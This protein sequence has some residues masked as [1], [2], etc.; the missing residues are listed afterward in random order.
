MRF[1]L[2][3]KL[4]AIALLLLAIPFTGFRFS[5]LIQSELLESRKETLLFSAQAVASALGGRTGLFD[6]ELFHSLNPTRDL[7][8]FH[9]T[10]PIRL[11]G[12]T[13]DWEPQLNEA[14]EYGEDNL[15]RSKNPYNYSSFHFRHLTG[16]RMEY[17]YALF[18][19]TDDYLVYR[20]PNSLRVDQSDH[21]RIAMEDRSGTLHQYYVT[22]KQEGWVNGFLM[23]NDKQP[24]VPKQVE[25]AIQGM[26][27]KTTE[28]Y[29]IELRMPLTMIGQKL[30]FALADVDDPAQPDIECLVGTAQVDSGEN[31]GWLLSPS[32]T[33]SS[34]LA[35]L[36]RPQARILVVDSNR[37]VR[38]NSGSLEI[39]QYEK[40]AGQTGT[41]PSLLSRLLRPVS[42]FFTQ[43]FSS[44]KPEINNQPTTLDLS[45][46]TEAL[47]GTSSV[48][49]YTPEEPGVEIMAAITPLREGD[50]VVGAVVVEQTTNSILALQNKVI[51]ES[52]GLTILVS[53][54]GGLGLL[55]YATRLS[56]RIRQLGTQAAGAISENGQINTTI[57]ASSV[58]DELGDLSRILTSMLR[59]LELQI[60][61]RE[62]M[63]D[64]LEHEI[65][66]PLAGISASLKNLKNEL[67]HQSKDILDYLDWA[68][69]DVGRLE[70]LLTTIRD[71]TSLQDALERDEK[72]D[73]D[74]TTAIHMWLLHGWLEAFPGV[75]FQFYPPDQ[76]LMLH[77][78]PARIRQMLDK[79]I[80]NAIEFHFPDTPITIS[81]KPHKASCELTICN[82][83][84]VIPPEQRQQIF[85]SMVS[86]RKEKSKVPHL[87]LGLYIVRTIVEHHR[88]TIQVHD[89]PDNSGTCFMVTI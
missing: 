73:F 72:E 36:S 84:P 25:K 24:P 74:I 20:R 10:N 32:E 52:I 78:D 14:R 3:L 79:L 23:E 5:E 9:L 51:E 50:D 41:S 67:G 68:L 35:S 12:K 76:P 19:V 63:A 27:Q 17:L 45:G 54:L 22:P 1:S 43:P 4:A 77:G 26:W 62:K 6:R 15:L 75:D 66:T 8:V 89:L 49:S 88:G 40:T 34:I 44:P 65:R 33:I 31:L 70:S 46:I 18:V 60:D 82:I 13:D 53:V 71:A 87:G 85:G 80:E 37:R 81:L 64:N 56:F 30:A 83:G 2:R 61:Y 38:A 7:Y 21:L 57:A 16:V 86:L 39:D 69:E 47:Q 11:N 55:I 48:S 28:G 58:N 42:R 29:I 59:Q